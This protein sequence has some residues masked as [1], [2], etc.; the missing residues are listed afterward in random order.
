MVKR[1]IKNMVILIL[2]FNTAM[3]PEK[4]QEHFSHNLL[5]EYKI[6][7]WVSTPNIACVYATESEL[8]LQI[9]LKKLDHHYIL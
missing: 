5:N 9:N 8:N 2:F 3:H 7:S 1:K 4:Q 6:T